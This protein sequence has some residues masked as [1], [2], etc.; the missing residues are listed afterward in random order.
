MLTV[1]V[2]VVGYAAENN[3]LAST[4]GLVERNPI[5]NNSNT[6]PPFAAAETVKPD[7]ALP[8]PLMIAPS[9]G[10]TAHT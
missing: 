4:K 2:F 3:W 10:R 1:T 9:E 7:S 6:S 5:P 8:V